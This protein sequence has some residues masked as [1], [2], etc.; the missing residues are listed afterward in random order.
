M[1]DKIT[2][3]AFNGVEIWKLVE[4]EPVGNPINALIRNEVDIAKMQNRVREAFI[5][6]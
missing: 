5:D 2:C 6:A 4:K 3:I 1:L